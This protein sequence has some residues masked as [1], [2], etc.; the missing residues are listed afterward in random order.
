MVDL[1]LFA[2]VLGIAYV[3]ADLA[4]KIQYVV[5]AVIAVSLVLVLGNMEVWRVAP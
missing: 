5:M 3:S 2:V 1:G 4:F